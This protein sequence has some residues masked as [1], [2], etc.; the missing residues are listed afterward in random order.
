MYDMLK[1]QIIWKLILMRC[2]KS[3]MIENKLKNVRKLN[4]F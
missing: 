1:N 4:H 2:I 3:S